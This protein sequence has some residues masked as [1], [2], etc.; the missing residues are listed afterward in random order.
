MTERKNITQPADW[1]AAFQGQAKRDG[2][3]LS[4]WVGYCCTEHLPQGKAKKLS[5]RPSVGAKKK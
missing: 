5:K 2:M 3:S 1:W 4:E